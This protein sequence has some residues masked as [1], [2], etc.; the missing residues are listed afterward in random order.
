MRMAP[1]GWKARCSGAAEIIRRQRRSIFPEV[2]GCSANQAS[3]LGDLAHCHVGFGRRAAPD[4]DVCLLGHRVDQ[5][6]A[7]AKVDPHVLKLFK[8]DGDRVQQRLPGEA[9]AG[10]DPQQAPRFAAR[11]GNIRFGAID[12][13]QHLAGALQID[14]AFRR[15]RQ[16]PR[17][18]GQQPHAEPVLHARHGLRQRRRSNAQILRCLGEAAEIVNPRKCL[19]ILRRWHS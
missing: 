1:S 14:R 6:V 12:Q 9:R 13:V 8:E 19:H 7:Q 17:R 11:G 10:I 4:D 2:G 3:T 16:P 18:A 5:A 15:Q